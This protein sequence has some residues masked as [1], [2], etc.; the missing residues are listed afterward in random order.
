MPNYT[1]DPTT[2]LDPNA[3]TYVAPVV[4][5]V[6]DS[7]PVAVDATATVQSGSTAVVATHATDVDPTDQGYISIS[8]YTDPLIDGTTT[9]AA[10]T[11][12]SNGNPFLL[13]VNGTFILNADSTL[14]PAFDTGT[15][16]V[17]FSYR[18][19]D[20]VH[21]E[22]ANWATVTITVNGLPTGGGTGGGTGGTGGGTGGTGSGV[23]LNPPNYLVGDANGPANDSIAGG[24]Q[25]DTIEG[26]VGNDTLL[27]QN[28]ED[29]L[30]GGAGADR[31]LGGN[32][33]DTLDGGS[34][35]DILTGGNGKDVFVIGSTAGH[36][37]IT[38]FDPK[39]E[40]IKV[41]GFLWGGYNDLMNHAVNDGHG[42]V[43]ITTDDHLHSLTLEGL[44]ASQLSAGDFIFTG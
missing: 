43:V 3:P 31:L 19:V 44:K 20:T 10:S 16:T 9:I 14:Y 40:T 30:L 22:S 13:A 35:D 7:A 38:D 39:G 32:G 15:H 28:G 17:T 33:K 25:N 4:N 8:E 27:G 5:G 36:V 34:G 23:G 11:A 29:S 6:A 1:A 2:F 26:R 24:N 21:V 18:A 42:N 12:T 41:S 37:H